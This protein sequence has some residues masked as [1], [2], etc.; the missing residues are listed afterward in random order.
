MGICPFLIK[1]NGIFAKQEKWLSFLFMRE[2]WGRRETE[3]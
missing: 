1:N 3:A 2:G